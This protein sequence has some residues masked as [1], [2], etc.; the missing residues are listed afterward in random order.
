MAGDLTVRPLET[1]DHEHWFRLWRSCIEFCEAN[2]EDRT[3]E[4]TWTR[5]LYHKLA[6]KT[7]WVR[8]DTVPKP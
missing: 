7:S 1:G 3:S 6:N 2:V 5:L 8:Y 4:I